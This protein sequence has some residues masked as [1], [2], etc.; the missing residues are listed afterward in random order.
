MAK[1]HL[2][3]TTID[4]QGLSWQMAPGSQAAVRYG[5]D[6]I[7]V[8]GLELVSGDQQISADGTFGRPG[9]ALKITMRNVDLAAVDTLCS[10][11]RSSK[12]GSTPPAFLRGTAGRRC[13]ATPSF[14]SVR[15]FRNFQHET[16]AGTVDYKGHGLTVDTKLQQNATQWL[17]AKVATCAA[18]ALHASRKRADTLI[19]LSRPRRRSRGPRSISPSTAVRSILGSSRASTTW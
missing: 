13:R 14:R 2:Q 1:L 7:V 11:P 8:R 3:R 15:S 16:F 5:D 12:D 18:G 6:A 19:C 9:D 17:T 4:T 10:V